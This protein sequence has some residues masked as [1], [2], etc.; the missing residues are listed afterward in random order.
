MKYAIRR[1]LRLGNGLLVLILVVT[2][3]PLAGVPVLA[4]GPGD[5]VINEIMQNPNAV[6]DSAGEWFELYNPTGSD[7][8]INGWT[9]K[10]EG[11]DSHVINNGGPLIVPAGGYLVLGNNA[12]ST[13]NGGVDAGYSYGANWFLA[14]GDDEVVLLDGTLVEIDRVEYDGG[15]LFPDP[16]GASMALADPAL[17]N[18]VGANWC[19]AS[20]PYGNGDLGTPGAANDCVAPTVE[21]VINEIMQNP[22]AVSDSAGEWFELYNPTGSD[23]DINGW[24]IKD[25][26]IDNHVIDNGGPLLVPAGGYLVLGN[27]ADQATNGGVVVAYAYPSSWYLGNSD[28]EVVLLDGTL[29]EIDR[30]EYDGGPLFPDPTGA[31]M[32]LIDP[33]LDNN[34]GANWCT[35]STPYGSGDLGTPGAANDC[36]APTV[37]VVINEIMQNPNAVSDSVGEWFELYNPTGSD[38]DING[39]TIKDEGIDSHVIDNGGPLLIP[40]GGYLVLGN[41]ADQAT[42]GGVVVAYAYPSSWYLGNSDDEVVLLDGTLTEIDRVEYDGGPLFPDPT[43]A[44]MSLIDPALDN[45]VGANWCTSATPYGNG[46]LGTPG[47]ANICEAP[48]QCGD[49]FTPIYG[50][51]GSGSA[52]PL[53]GT[54]VA[55][56]G[57]VVGDFQNNGQPD[58]GDLNGFHIQD[59]AGDGDTAT[60]DGIFVYAPGGMDVSVG[61]AVRVRG[62]VSEYNG[63][64][65]IT[66]SQVWQCSTGNSVAPTL[67]SL[68]VASLDDFEA[69]EGMLVTF[70]QPLYISEYFNFD[71]Y[72]EI[73]LTTE[74]QYQP[75]ATFDPGSPEAAQLAQDNLLGRITLDDG[76]SSQNPDPAIHPNG[77]VF[78]LTNLFRGGDTVTNVTGVLD[79][80]FDL[81]R[82]QPTQGADYAPVNLRTPAPDDVGG[83]L[84]VASFNVLNYFTTIDTGAWI[85][86]PAGDQ[87]C[88]GADTPE[89]FTRQRAKIIAALSAINADVVGLIEIENHPGDVPAADLVSGL[90]DA[91]GAGTY[92]YIATGAIGTDAIR[93]AFIYKPAIVCPLGDFAVLDDPSFTD[94]LNYDDQ[95]SRPALAQSFID[96][97]TGGVFTAVVNHLKSKSCYDYAT[98]GDLDQGD[99]RG[100]FNVTRKLGAQA[101][102]DWLAGDPTGSG[103]ADFLI[104]GDL[105]SYDKEDP[106]DV[107][108]A[109][110]Y[111][112]LLSE[113]LGEYAY[114]YVFDGQLGYLDHALANQDLLGEVTGVTVWHINADEPDLI[115]YDTSFKQPA[116][117]AIYAPDAYRSSDHDPVIAGLDVCDEIPPTLDVSVAPDMLWPPNHKYVEVTATVDA[118]DNFD[119]SPTVTL[120][121]VTSNEPDNGLDDGDTPN[122]IV[123]VDDTTFQLRA[124]RSGIGEGRIYTITY[125]AT[126]A[127]GNTTV[128]TATVTVPLSKGEGE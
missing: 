28:D 6:L 102:I 57:I 104:I 21:V 53:V 59:P 33:A 90:N 92:N 7:I 30:V 73:V 123:I 62:T 52:S 25:E 35:A 111:T 74:R 68:P 126:D 76:R 26:G 81:Y 17:D 20:T 112:D 79:Y 45:N 51:Q 110:E 103:D 70:E 95:Q 8:D 77:G 42:N 69:Y 12:D 88:R 119:P 121:S 63:M 22:N 113:F 31:S 96:K 85:C 72:G 50:V 67:L 41:N 27:N 14:N 18:N 3:V 117:D 84:K 40:A 83:N 100:C 55:V 13:T 87:E 89:E 15:P 128:T 44:S 2:M 122:D 10:D 58:N 16:T 105:N 47:A 32:S 101:L 60:S 43:G 98:D 107:L 116:Q 106:I 19:T 37:E 23:I 82:I 38:I 66:A 78:D 9:I 39:W 24:T 118:S 99:G 93:Q 48:E 46:D 49:P 1:M 54:E 124:E 109:G 108:L 114:S 125:Q 5:I 75:T 4:A 120:V 71:R 34:V 86:G 29:T 56:E 127:C 64:T 115:D 80:S 91:L 61:D 36:V 94:P 97:A 65:E 11:S